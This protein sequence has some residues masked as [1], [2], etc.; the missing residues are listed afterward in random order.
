MPCTFQGK[1]GFSAPRPGWF[2]A[3][4]SHVAG[5][6][7]VLVPIVGAA[8]NIGD[9]TA[10]GFLIF[11]ESIIV[12]IGEIIV[13]FDIDEIFLLVL[14][15]RFTI[16]AG[17]LGLLGLTC[18]RFVDFVD[19]RA[20]RGMRDF[21]DRAANRTNDRIAIEIIKSGT[22][23]AALAGAFYPA[24][25]LGHGVLCLCRLEKERALCHTTV[26]L[27]KLTF[28]DSESSLI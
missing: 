1:S 17:E 21:V 8:N 25:V 22:A 14:L 4:P 6:G 11:K 12:G 5:L 13:G 24:R 3:P 19:H 9:I 16:G 28:G 15:I 18:R 23:F 7:F 10:V 27:S 26:A 2:L 20:R